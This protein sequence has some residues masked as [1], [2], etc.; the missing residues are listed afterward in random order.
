MES[1][2]SSLEEPNLRESPIL[3]DKPI[4]VQALLPFVIFA[5]AAG[6]IRCL[7]VHIAN[8]RNFSAGS[9]RAEL[10]PL[11]ATTGNPVLQLLVPRMPLSP[12]P[13]FLIRHSI[14][15]RRQQL[16]DRCCQHLE[17]VVRT[18]RP[19]SKERRRRVRATYFS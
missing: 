3:R 18:L 17:P 19:L 1:G 13:A 12:L 4:S 15:S 16:I 14:P 2:F 7:D 10:F 5:L 11:T 6:F 9:C 8:Y